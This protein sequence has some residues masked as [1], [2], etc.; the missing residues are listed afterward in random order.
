MSKQ[1]KTSAEA[2]QNCINA[3]NGGKKEKD[4]M[5]FAWAAASIFWREQ[6]KEAGC[7]AGAA[8]IK[9]GGNNATSFGILVKDLTTTV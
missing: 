6:M 3:Y 2:L 7:V 4:A 8:I 1:V 9:S 5:Q